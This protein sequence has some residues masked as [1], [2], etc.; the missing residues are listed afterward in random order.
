[1]YASVVSH[2]SIH[3]AFLIVVLNDLEVLSVD[4]QNAYLKAP[5][6]ERVYTTVGG[7]FGKDKQG[8]PVLI[9]RALH[10]L[11]SSGAHWR[12]HMAATLQDFGYESYQA[13]P[14][15]WMKPDVK[16]DGTKYW[17]YVLCY[18]WRMFF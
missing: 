9:V 6:T 8:R 14:D 16:R 5:T 12:N 1:V 7:E 4:V 15:V 13:G 18:L 3:L 17:Q 11:T 2:D 10:G